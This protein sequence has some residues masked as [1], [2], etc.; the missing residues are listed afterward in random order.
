MSFHPI[1]EDLSLAPEL[2]ALAAPEGQA[3][4]SFKAEAERAG[5]AVPPKSRELIS[6]GV[7]LTT[8]C[9]YCL[10]AHARN[11]RR[12][13]ATRAEVAE[14]VFL[15]AALRAGAAA[16]HGLMALRPFDA[17]AGSE[18]APAPP[19]AAGSV[20]GAPEQEATS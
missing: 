11:A 17:E 20:P 2:V 10:E 8:K 3:F 6:L 4:L 13:G 15:A 5:G 12:S 7:A 1:P 16:G 19:R 14:T 9:G 18:A